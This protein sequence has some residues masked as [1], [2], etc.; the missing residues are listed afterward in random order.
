MKKNEETTKS[1]ASILTSLLFFCIIGIGITLLISVIGSFLVLSEILDTR[2]I[3][4]FSAFSTFA[5]A[6][7]AG[8]FS[9]N[10]LGKPLFTSFLASLLFLLSLY[11]IGALLYGRIIP[12]SPFLPTVISILAAAVISSFFNALRHPTKKPGNKH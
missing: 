11:L 5:G 6:F 8:L 3:M 9:C 10:K 7:V 2:Y 12:Q 4:Y 1:I